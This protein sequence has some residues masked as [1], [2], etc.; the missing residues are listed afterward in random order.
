M[1]S[2]LNNFLQVGVLIYVQAENCLGNKK[3]SAGSIGAMS[4]L[5]SYRGETK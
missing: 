2:Y 1:I 5:Q 4:N 3:L